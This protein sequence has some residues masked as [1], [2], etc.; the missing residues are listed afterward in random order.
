M[1]AAAQP[2]YGPPV[3]QGR[4]RV[5][6]GLLLALVGACTSDQWPPPEDDESDEGE[7]TGAAPLEGARLL[8]FEPESPSIHYMGEPMPL[9]AEVHDTSGLLLDFDEVVW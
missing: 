1:E 2:C 3:L 6:A 8:V 5:H 9:L 7:S 4:C